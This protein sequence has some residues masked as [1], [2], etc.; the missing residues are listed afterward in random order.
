MRWQA[1]CGRQLAIEISRQIGLCTWRC[2]WPM[3][4]PRKSPSNKP[5]SGEGCAPRYRSRLK[6][7]SLIAEI[8]AGAASNVRLSSLQLPY[9]NFKEGCEN[10]LERALSCTTGVRTA[11]LLERIGPFFRTWMEKVHLA[12]GEGAKIAAVADS[13]LRAF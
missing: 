10:M 12:S 11:P 1:K 7:E 2:Q 3:T 8:R 9:S 13:G 5:T 4:P 6:L